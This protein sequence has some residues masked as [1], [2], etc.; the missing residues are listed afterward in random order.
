MTQQEFK[1]EK[2]VTEAEVAFLGVPILVGQ[3]V[4]VPRAETELLARSALGLFTDQSAALR[5]VDMCCGSGN[6]AFAIAGNLPSAK[7]W[8]SDLTDQTIAS[9]AANCTRLRMED[10]V[11]VCQGD[12]FSALDGQALEGTVDLIVANPPYISSA[13][14]ETESAQLLDNEPREAFDGGPYGISIHQRLVKE[15]VAFLKPGG[16]LAFEFGLGQDRQAKA[17][18]ARTRAYGEPVF[19]EDADGNPRVAMAQRLG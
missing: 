8:A 9:C 6:L 12:L 7:V 11:T 4:L 15:A 14:L 5:V 10:R 1:T 13:R 18:I 17:L 19:V 16:W 3:D 2:N